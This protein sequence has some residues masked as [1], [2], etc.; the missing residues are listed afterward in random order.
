MKHTNLFLYLT[1]LQIPA[2]YFFAYNELTACTYTAEKDGP[3]VWHRLLA[4]EFDVTKRETPI[5]TIGVDQA[6]EHDKKIWKEKED[7]VVHHK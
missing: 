4:G 3:D 5:T 7:F 2:T 6:Q 1:S